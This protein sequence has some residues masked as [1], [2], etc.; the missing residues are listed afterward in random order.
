MK[1][2]LSGAAIVCAMTVGTAALGSIQDKAATTQPGS[3]GTDDTFMR[4]AAMDGLAEVEH[5]KLA[6]QN[7]A[8]SDVKQF[9]QRMVDE[10]G[11]GNAEL[12]N[13]AAKKNVTL[14]TEL[15]AKHKAMQD[16]LSKLN[17]TAFDSAYMAHMVSAHKEAVSLFERE[18]KSGKDADT[19]AFAAKTLPTLQQHLKMAQDLSAKTS[20]H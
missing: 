16:K 1:S 19:K 17:G 10:H 9:G 13:L 11:K 8:S 7:A 12:K 15:D 20:I 2:L 14:P 5:G 6:A 18:A 3:A 4:T